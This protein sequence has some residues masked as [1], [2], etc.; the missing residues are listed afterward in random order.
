M[1][2]FHPKNGYKY[3]YFFPEIEQ[4]GERYNTFWDGQVDDKEDAFELAYAITVHKSQGSDFDNVFLVIPKRYGLLCKELI[5]TALTRAKEKLFLFVQ[6][7]KVVQGKNKEPHSLLKEAQNSSMVE[8]RKTSL[9]S[10]PIA[11]KELRYDLN[12]TDLVDEQKLREF[13]DNFGCNVILEID[14]LLSFNATNNTYDEL[15]G[16]IE[17][18]MEYD[19]ISNKLYSLLL[20]ILFLLESDNDMFENKITEALDYH[21]DDNGI[22]KFHKI[23]TMNIESKIE[24]DIIYLS[25]DYDIQII[26]IINVSEIELLNGIDKFILKYDINYIDNYRNN[27][28]YG[29]KRDFIHDYNV[30]VTDAKYKFLN[31]LSDY[32]LLYME[33]NMYADRYRWSIYTNN[34]IKDTLLNDIYERDNN[35]KIVRYTPKITN[36]SAIVWVEDEI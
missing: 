9:F 20:T 24:D 7:N 16:G 23:N 1:A 19:G 25:E 11:S 2:T 17:G 27:F 31:Q 22:I 12:I 14:G 35:F 21:S 18:E 36:P 4:A 34:Q 15:D 28:W 30:D 8:D 5:Y 33:K 13:R 10:L 6:E 3:Q 32:D 26:P 29:Y